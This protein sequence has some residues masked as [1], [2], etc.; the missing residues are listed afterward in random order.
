M[1]NNILNERKKFG[2][3]KNILDDDIPLPLQKDLQGEMF[4]RIDSGINDVDRFL[5]FQTEK[6]N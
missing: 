6:Q 3:E 2:G 1:R 4:L 5:I